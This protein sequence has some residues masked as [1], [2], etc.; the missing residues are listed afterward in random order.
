MPTLGQESGHGR[1]LILVGLGVIAA[2]LAIVLNFFATVPHVEQ[3][4]RPAPTTA[5]IAPEPGARAGTE[6]EPAPSFDVVRVHPTGDA[7]MAGRASPGSTVVIWDGETR[8]GEVAADGRGEWVFLPDTPLAAGSHRLR[9]E[10]LVADEPAVISDDEVL[11]IVPRPG[12][13]IAGRPGTGGEQPLA[14]RMSRATGQPVGILQRPTEGG[15]AAGLS[16]DAV[17]YDA[18]GGTHVIGRGTPG[19]TLRLYVN[20]RLLGETNVGKDG[21]WRFTATDPLPAGRY[22]IRAEQ[23]GE[24]GSVTARDGI[25]FSAAAVPPP[26]TNQIVVERGQSLW[27]IA[28]ETYGSGPAYTVIFEINRQQIQDPDRI[29]PG[30]VL[31][32]PAA[33][34]ETSVKAA[35]AQ[36]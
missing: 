20:D 23:V 26:G 32:L 33:P 5:S 3:Q 22:G 34:A 28:R 9:L 13:D 35:P 16:I 25:V 24:G 31:R 19:A 4:V 18:R 27:R 30:Q 8:L 7:V 21:T 2:V 12:E 36:R 17:D 10:V 15:T 14:M 11:I 29:Y 6:G 1:A